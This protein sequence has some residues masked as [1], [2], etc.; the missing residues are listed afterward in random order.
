M[1]FLLR[2]E[3][4]RIINVSSEG[5]RMGD[6]TFSDVDAKNSTFWSYKT[7]KAYGTSKLANILHAIE[8]SRR[9]EGKLKAV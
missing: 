8:L 9:H 7:Y 6:I 1:P 5:H 3:K 2:A 4:P